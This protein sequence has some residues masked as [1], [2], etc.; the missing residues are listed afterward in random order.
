M[1]QREFINFNGSG[2]ADKHVH[3]WKNNSTPCN[4]ETDFLFFF[5]ETIYSK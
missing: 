1:L 4:M 5:W 2:V 3:I